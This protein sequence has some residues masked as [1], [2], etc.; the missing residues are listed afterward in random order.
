MVNS[1]SHAWVLDA[2]TLAQ[3]LGRDDKGWQSL[4]GSHIV[5]MSKA[6]GR[7]IIVS[8]HERPMLPYQLTIE[9]NNESGLFNS[10]NLQFF[11][12]VEFDSLERA[13]ELIRPHVKLFDEYMGSIKAKGKAAELLAER[14]EL[15]TREQDDRLAAQHDDIQHLKDAVHSTLDMRMI[16]Q[17]EGIRELLENV[18][19]RN[20]IDPDERKRLKQLKQFTLLAHYFHDRFKMTNNP[21]DAVS[22]C[23]NWRKA[24]PRRPDLTLE[25][26]SVVLDGPWGRDSQLISAAWTTKGG[27]FRDMRDMNHARRCANRALELYESEHPYNLLGAIG[28]SIATSEEDL[29]QSYKWFIIPSNASQSISKRIEWEMPDIHEYDPEAARRAAK[30]LFE[31]DSKS[32]KWAR[33]YF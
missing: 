14:A 15:E 25:L 1:S 27:A 2:K 28:F 33:R 6:Y 30:W 5:H 19:R 3:L 4:V 18:R 17:Q 24:T 22:A 31:K 32:F 26:S 13:H 23:S 21:W 11:T 9:F 29:E 8:V 16:L 12:L 10:D 20:K 7:G